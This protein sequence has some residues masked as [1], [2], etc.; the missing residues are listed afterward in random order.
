M[1]DLNKEISIFGYPI[2]DRALKSYRPETSE[3]LGPLGYRSR[4]VRRCKAEG[5]LPSEMGGYR[6][7]KSHHLFIL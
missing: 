6:I 5:F 3:S 2:V 7:A 1:S 4:K